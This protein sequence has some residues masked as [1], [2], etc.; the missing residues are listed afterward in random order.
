[1]DE[2]SETPPAPEHLLERKNSSNSFN[3]FFSFLMK[4][5]AKLQFFDDTDKKMKPNSYLPDANSS[6]GISSQSIEQAFCSAGVSSSAS[7]SI[8]S[9]YLVTTRV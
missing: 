8:G 4:S 7:A 3:S 5:T 6:Y 1:M 2:R 9:S